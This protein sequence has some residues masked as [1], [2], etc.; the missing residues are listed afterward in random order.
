MIHSLNNDIYH[1]K[2]S[3]YINLF[4]IMSN[5]QESSL[6]R[7]IAELRKLRDET[8]NSNMKPFSSIRYIKYIPIYPT[9]FSITK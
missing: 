8:L 9:Y 5:T 1:L 4:I 3:K 7:Q 2:K 6:K